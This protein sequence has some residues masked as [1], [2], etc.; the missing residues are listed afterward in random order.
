MLNHIWFF[1]IVASLL[2]AAI[3]GSLPQVSDA[4]MDGAGQAVELSIFMLGGM[5]A[6]LGFLNIA[7]KSGLTRL[8]AKL[9]SPVIDRL[10]PEYQGDLEIQGKICMNLSANLL[11][12]GNAATPIGLSAMKAMEDRNQTDHPTKGMMLFVLINTAS[13]QLLPVNMAAIRD[14]CGSSDPF[15]I[16]PKVWVTSLSALLIVVIL[17]K[18]AERMRIWKN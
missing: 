5:C 16:L 9:L 15:G 1:M 11:G 2:F 17:A 10:F 8:L 6:W 14:S 3:N 13:I 4:L 7:E 12:L 18:A